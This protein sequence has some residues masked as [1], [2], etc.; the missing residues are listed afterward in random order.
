MRSRWIIIYVSLLLEC[1]FALTVSGAAPVFDEPSAVVVTRLAD[2][3]LEKD[4]GRF[5]WDRFATD[6]ALL[7]FRQYSTNGWSV[8]YDLFSA[9]L[10]R[11]AQ[12]AGMEADAL[13]EILKLVLETHQKMAYL[14][15]AAY[16]CKIGDHECWIVLCKWE[17]LPQGMPKIRKTKDGMQLDIPAYS[18]SHVRMFAYDLGSKRSVAF[19]TCM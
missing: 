2:T 7:G 5:L 18:L 4:A 6:P 12:N 1:S 14:P 11:K 15:V 9:E 13:A 8:D 17:E 19:N 3:V 10:V 16:R